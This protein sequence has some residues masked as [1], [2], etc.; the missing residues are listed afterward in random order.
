MLVFLH[1]NIGLVNVVID[2]CHEAE[3]RWCACH[4]FVNWYFETDGLGI[5]V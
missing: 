2:A 4:I 5:G 1:F 3:R